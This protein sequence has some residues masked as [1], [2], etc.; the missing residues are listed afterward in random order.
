MQKSLAV[1]RGA[2]GRAGGWLSQLLGE[3][4]PQLGGVYVSVPFPRQQQDEQFVSR[5]SE[6]S[7]YT[8]GLPLQSARVSNYTELRFV[9]CRPLIRWAVFTS[10]SKS[11][12][13]DC[14]VAVPHH[15]AVAEDALHHM[16]WSNWRESPLSSV[17]WGRRFFVGPSSSERRCSVTKSDPRWC[18]GPG[19]W[20]YP[21]TPPTSHRSS[22]R[23]LD[24]KSFFLSAQSNVLKYFGNF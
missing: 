18:G 17:S 13:L 11:S 19:I 9:S 5:V 15:H 6:V 8:T 1:C 2:E 4:F 22:W 12:V 10:R 21:H 24:L 16:F 23:V 3:S 14:A 20:C 7:S